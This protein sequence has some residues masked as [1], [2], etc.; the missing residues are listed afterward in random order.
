[1]GSTSIEWTRGD[2]GTPGKTWNP[3]VGCSHTSPGCDGCYAARDAFGRL[4]GNPTY[5]GLAERRHPDELPRFTGEI[6]LLPDRLDQPLRWRKPARVFVNSMSDLFHPDVPDS[7]IAQVFGVMKAAHG[8][9]F[10]IL[11]KR[12]RRMADLL[13][14]GW[15]EDT[16]DDYCAEISHYDTQWPLPNVWL[17]TSIESQAYAFRARH[18]LETPAAVRFVS[19]EPLLGPLDLTEYLQDRDE[20]GQGR[21]LR[22]L[23]H[24]VR[25]ALVVPSCQRLDWVIC[26]GE[27]GPGAR[28]MRPEW[29]RSLRDR[30]LA[31]GVAFHFKQAG[32]AL[33]R[34][35]GCAD[36][37]GGDWDAWPTDLRIRQYPHG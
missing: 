22:T 5:A 35:W 34:E 10:Q 37:K 31:A 24:P 23:G 14:A 18:L 16:A 12:S 2:D 25:L 36:Y 13:S 33:G 15:F 20:T 3:V 32:T 21:V 17:G 27:S 7:F 6:R 28:P 30:C 29:A 9:T 4:S 11:T 19:A 8:H 1:M 26:G